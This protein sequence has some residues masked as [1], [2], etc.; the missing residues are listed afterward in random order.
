MVP[1]KAAVPV[2]VTGDGE[3]LPPG[4][5]VEFAPSKFHCVMVVCAMILEQIAKRI[6]AVKASRYWYFAVMVRVVEMDDCMY[7]HQNPMLNRVKL[8]GYSD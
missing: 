7:Y 4:I 6:K 3:R 1:T 8:A 5:E 2:P